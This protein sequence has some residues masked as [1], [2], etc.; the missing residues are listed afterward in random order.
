MIYLDYAATSWPKP[1]GV[2]KAMAY[3]LE[4]SGGN[5]GRSG[6]RLS[7]EAAR[8]VY[9]AREAIASFF[10]L[11]D[12]MRVIFTSNATHSLNTVIHGLLGY[13]D[14]VVTSASEH[15]A[16]MRP[17]R[18]LEKDGLKLS[19]IPCLPDGSLKTDEMESVIKPGTKLVAILHASNV[20]G[21]IMPV[22]DVAKAAH[23]AGAL[24]L[25]DA[26]QTGGVLPVDMKEM[27]AD[28]IAITGHK[29]LLGSTGIGVLLISPDFDTSR[30]ESFIQGGTGSRSELEEQ[31]DFLPDKYESGT[32]NLAGIAGLLAGI[33]W[34]QQKGIEQINAH[35]KE[36]RQRLISGLSIIRGVEIYGRQDSDSSVAIVSITIKGKNASEVGF[37]LDEEFG[38]LTRVGLHCAPAAHHSIGS[39]PEGTVRLAPGIFTTMNDI[40]A[41]LKAIEAIA[42]S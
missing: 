30:L 34:I 35:E 41:T 8:I 26:A 29:G 16:V 23:K 4:C 28:F 40:D 33:R 10:N 17:L 42:H 37:R 7:I 20:S 2:T 13:G 3:A 36:L 12:P 22:A 24:I 21:T 14:A 6:H 39:F 38:I 31:P 5:P 18:N 1:P 9:D 19:A 25:V 11:D 15:N 32:A 27:G